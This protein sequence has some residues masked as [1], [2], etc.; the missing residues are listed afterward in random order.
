MIAQAA[1]HRLA[2][3]E[4]AE[5]EHLAPGPPPLLRVEGTGRED[6]DRWLPVEISISCSG[7]QVT[8]APALADRERATLLIPATFPFSR[9]AVQVGHYRFAGLPYV[10]LGRHICLYHSDA[11][12]DPATGMFGVIERLAAWYRRMATGRLVEAGQ[13]LHPPLAY[14]L[15]P[16]ADCVVIRADLPSDFTPAAAVMVR[17]HP[18]RVD[19][20]RWLRP[21]AIDVARRAV[22][23]H[24]AAD[25]VETAR[26]HGGPAFL[27]AALMLGEPMGFEFPHSFTG[28]VAAL[29]DQGISRE[30]LLDDLTDVWL[31]NRVAAVG[32]PDLAPLHVA[33]G[34]PMRGH[35]GAGPRDTHLEVWQLDAAEALIPPFVM[36]ADADGAQRA[37]SV[38]TARRHAQEWMRDATITW[39]HVQEARNQIVT[40]RDVRTPAQWL[41]GR[42]VLI[43][44]CGALGARIAE[45]CARAGVSTLVLADKDDVGPGILVRQPYQD[46]DIGQP[47]ARQLAERLTASGPSGIEIR[48]EVGDVRST[49]LGLDGSR[50]EADL[51]VDATANRGVSARIEWLRRTQRRRWPPVLTVG[52]GHD[53]ER[54]LAALALPHASGAGTDILHSFAD[55]AVR[56]DT[57]RDAADDFF[58]DPQ[59]EDVFQPEIGCSEPTF[60]GSDP[61]AAAAAGQAFAWALRVLSDHAVHRA[62][63]PKSLFYAR[64]P[65]SRIEPSHLYLDWQNDLASDDEMTGYQVRIRPEAVDALRRE[66]RRADW[67]F[68]ASC[69]TGGVLLGYLDD[70]CRVAWITAAEGAPP[71]SF[72]GQ[73]AFV[74]GTEGVE[75]R[76][77]W[78]HA[79]SRGRIRFVGMWHTHPGLP[80][81]ASQADRQAMTDFIGQVPATTSAR[82]AVLLIIGGEAERWGNWLRGIG[83][84]DIQF[85]LFTHEQLAQAD[86]AAG[87]QVREL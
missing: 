65:G 28:L 69:E 49:V 64:M 77:R 22:A 25:L 61:Q 86:E 54:V 44:G 4:L 45:H 36:L 87:Q 43:L 62:V 11:D 83:S 56:D 8:A 40:R 24:L 76:V 51:V 33:I 19:L 47:K 3:A 68:G 23:D 71:D 14:H 46:D 5:I 26:S 18:W 63:A 74:L 30:D 66:A 84:P 17:R 21:T 34:A 75:R 20:V 70:A 39:A 7:V 80:V 13:P 2:L 32:Q 6:D 52:V 12:W 38:M 48:A 60:T 9:P 78:H 29:A 72:H 73:L 85:R 35:A 16:D 50:P 10:L 42:T 55:R 27:A 59:P 57:L 41:L 15:S 58:A 81:A 67:D 53:C 79:K 1:G 31:A 37:A 82:R